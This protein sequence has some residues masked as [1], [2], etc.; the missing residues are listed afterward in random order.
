[1]STVT[2]SA[3]ARAEAV[4]PSAARGSHGPMA[5]LWIL[6]AIVAALVA[7]TFLFAAL[8]GS[9]LEPLLLSLAC[10]AFATVGVLV[11]TRHPRN[12]IG[13]IYCWVGLG[14]TVSVFAQN[15]ASY[16]IVHRP[17]PLPGSVEMA[18]V[19]S[20]T[21]P[22]SLLP[23]VTLSLLLFPDGHLPS[24]S[25][26]PLAWVATT[27]TLVLT[28][29]LALAPIP[30]DAIPGID[31]PFAIRFIPLQRLSLIA[32]AA[33]FVTLACAIASAGA[34]VVRL[35]GATG[36][37]RQQLKWMTYSAGLFGIGFVLSGLVS[38]FA[39]VEARALAVPGLVALPVAAGVAIFKYR[40]YDIDLV[41]SKT[42]VFGTLA[43]FITT[44]YVAVVVGLGTAIGAQGEP[45]LVLSILGAAIV[46]AA[47]QP[48]RERVE[49]LANR[50]VYGERATPYQ[51]L[52][53]FSERMAGASMAEELLPRMARLLAEGTGTARAD[54]WLR[55][56]DRLRRVAGWPHGDSP[57]EPRAVHDALRSDG[58]GGTRTE[59]V[60]HDGEVLGA[61]AVQ[62]RPGSPLGPPEERLVSDL[63]GQA[64]LV[65]RNVRLIEDLRA[66][67][68]RLVTTRDAE[69][70]RL[71]QDIR[72]RVERRLSA[73]ATALSAA[74][75]M[76][77]V[78][79]QGR[80][81]AELRE[82]TAGALAELRDLA[83]GVYPPF[84]ACNGLVVALKAQTRGSAVPVSI[85]AEA[86]G[87]YP[88]DVEAAA[89][90]CCLEALQNVAKHAQA[91]W[92]TVTLG[93]DAGMLRFTVD[94]DGVGFEPASTTSGSGLQN[95]ADRAAALGGHVRVRSAPGQ[96]ATISGWLPARTQEPRP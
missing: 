26:W 7:V 71:E 44:V 93:E 58:R 96:G 57:P 87:R 56:G 9:S 28:A 51:V 63:A 40:L 32:D 65:L 47:F 3:A 68:E 25:W 33:F 43:V 52:A 79:L 22:L 38:Y 42:V 21:P 62:V 39:H 8:A 23:L 54:V 55:Y 88:Q 76:G 12:A 94:D 31:N 41:I 95:M 89:Y 78:D 66:S 49:R 64:G 75:L 84:L 37:T 73:V 92:A 72:D 30:L 60:R 27:A 4:R 91:G 50:L 15:Y 20:W 10:L 85:Q 14:G 81:F 35:R 86:V 59:L 67:R 5:L 82:E 24:R 11:V 13:W 53:E 19:A 18:W 90:F 46:A 16:G 48:V 6:E 77:D 61:L 69:R 17:S 80:L 34:M 29:C 45:S 74:T 36:E 70:R 1:V 83:R 2:T